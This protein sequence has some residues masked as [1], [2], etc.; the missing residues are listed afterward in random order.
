MSKMTEKAGIRKLTNHSA[1][2]HLVQKLN[3]ANIPA[4]HIMQITGHK[5]VNSINNYSSL[6][7]NQQ[8]EISGIIS[9]RRTPAAAVGAPPEQPKE[10]QPTE[11]SRSEIQPRPS[12]DIPIGHELFH[13]CQFKVENMNINIK[14]LTPQ[15]QRR[16]NFIDSDSD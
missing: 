4:N 16:R 2:K 6:T 9:G 10:I 7:I 5:N 3:D 12:D 1:R 11:A 15:V 13:N 14:Y 8:K